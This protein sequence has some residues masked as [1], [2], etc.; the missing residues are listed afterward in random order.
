MATTDI[1]IGDN[2]HL[3]MR[4]VLQDGYIPFTYGPSTGNNNNISA[5]IYCNADAINYDNFD[6]IDAPVAGD[7][8]YCVAFNAAVPP[9]C[10]DKLVNQSSEQCD[11][12]EFCTKNC[13]CA[14]GYRSEQGNCVKIY[15][16]ACGNGQIDN[17]LQ[18]KD[19]LVIDLPSEECDDGNMVDGDGC[20]ANCT[21]EEICDFDNV[22]GWYGEYFNY[23]SGH[24][25]MDLPVGQWNQSNVYGDPLSYMTPRNADWYHNNYFKFSQVDSNLNFGSSF[26]PLDV[27]V[28]ELASNGHEHHFGVHWAAQTYISVAGTYNFN[29]T[30]DDDIWVYIDGELVGEADGI[31]PATSINFSKSLTVGT[32]IFDI[33]YADRHKVQAHMDFNSLENL[34]FVPYNDECNEVD[35]VCGN[36]MLEGTEECDDGNMVDGDGCS[37][38]CTLS[39]CVP[40][41]NLVIN[42]GFEDPALA[43]GTW[44]IIPNV[45]GGWTVEVAGTDTPD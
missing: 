17:S 13:T 33:Y 14:E 10:G 7:T 32:H 19:E 31:H 6:R 29:A 28:D 9:T 1:T 38:N 11:G 18:G 4:E 37:A 16:P 25:G 24:L 26:Y 30:A 3:W 12:S 41:Q 45:A 40:Q 23:L 43:A 5:E 36:T 20:S 22:N 34:L 42:G 27:M 39:I 15:F 2:D 8:Y 21:I 35:P 44:S